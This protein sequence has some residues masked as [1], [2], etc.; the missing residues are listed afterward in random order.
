MRV[1]HV[2]EVTTGG[3]A[4]MLS[5]VVPA[6]LAAG[7]EVTVCMPTRLPAVPA[8]VYVPW[9]V[10]RRLGEVVSSVGGLRR[11]AASACPDVV[12]LHS[13]VAGSL[14]RVG[15]RTA[16]PD[17]ALLY[18]PH[19][20]NFRAARD[21]VSLGGLVAVEAVLGRCS[22]RL[23]VNCVAEVEEGR[24]HGVAVPASVIGLPVDLERFAPPTAAQRMAAR[25]GR[26]APGRRLVVAVGD[27]SWQKGQDRL[28][29]AWERSP[30]PGTDLVLVGGHQPRRLR[31]FTADGLA[32]FAPRQ[33]GATVRAV[34]H[35]DD[36][37][38]WLHAADVVALTSRYESGCVAL[39]EALAS[40]TP[41][42]TTD[43]A[44]ASEAV[45]AGPE[46][47][48]GEVVACSATADRLPDGVLTACAALT[49][50]EA[51]R[52]RRAIAARRRAERVFSPAAVRDRLDSAYVLA[53]QD[54]RR[55]L[56]TASGAR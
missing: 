32:R 15:L 55:A 31:P 16:V 53:L 37:R 49:A 5:D 34:G 52:D 25:C 36:V 51:L 12:H 38:P 30:L 40:G 20:W 33:W 47:P 29:A 50:D 35:Q 7:H 22:D 8:E 14:G 44:G 54:R 1:L 3:V 24:R 41:V 19:S 10:S 27:L 11:V 13:F 2:S 46:E 42:V 21:P 28:V 9:Q 26:V 6:Q 18:Q 4:A 48:A 43:F 23:V 56:A 17:A 45:L 39:G